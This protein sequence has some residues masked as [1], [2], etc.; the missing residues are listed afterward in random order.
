ML[1][2]LYEKKED[3]PADVV[4]F[5]EENDDGVFILSIDGV[6]PDIQRLKTALEDER[7]I[8]GKSDKENKRLKSILGDLTSDE[9]QE[10]KN[11]QEKFKTSIAKTNTEM[12]ARE[13][14]LKEKWEVIVEDRDKTISALDKDVE[15]YVV[16]SHILSV[17]A[18]KD[19]SGDPEVLYDPIRKNTK[20]L[21]KES[22]GFDFKVL[23]AD[24]EV[25]VGDNSGNDMG[26]KQ[27][28]LEFKQ[29]KAF[30]SAFP[31]NSGGDAPGNN[32]KTN[33]NQ[34]SEA[35]QSLPPGERLRLFRENKTI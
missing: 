24:G 12:E 21:R 2:Y 29:K 1:K 23:G 6:I 8:S 33:N 13:K 35:F 22:G 9:I 4:N 28:A 30:A 16:R 11:N 17:L 19:V 10:L 34:T 3:I 18:D 5:Y 14:Q 27:Y 31:E 25:K 15:E 26:V 20:V 7:K 32:G